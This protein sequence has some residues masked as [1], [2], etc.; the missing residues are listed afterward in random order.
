M[1][2]GDRT[3]VERTAVAVSSDCAALGGCSLGR[4]ASMTMLS[5][6]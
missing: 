6:S 4:A 5:V 3:A 1:S 2:H